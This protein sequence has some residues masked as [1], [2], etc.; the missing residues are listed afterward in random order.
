[1]QNKQLFVSYANNYIDIIDF[2]TRIEQ[3]IKIE[4]KKLEMKYFLKQIA[5]NL[6]LIKE[7]EKMR[8]NNSENLNLNENKFSFLENDLTEKN[9]YLKYKYRLLEFENK[10]LLIN[11]EKNQNQNFEYLTNKNKLNNKLL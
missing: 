7:I 1:M 3:G 2:R 6:K 10:Q 8:N 5:L 9:N 11:S 4:D